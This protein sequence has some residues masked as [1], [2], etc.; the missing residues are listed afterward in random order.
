MAK[1]GKGIFQ[2]LYPWLLYYLIQ[3]YKT[4]IQGGRLPEEGRLELSFDGGEWG[5]V[6]GDGWGIREAM[7]ACKQLG[8]LYD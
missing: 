3:I 7:V 5:V 6:C 2:L 8:N 1:L 4:F